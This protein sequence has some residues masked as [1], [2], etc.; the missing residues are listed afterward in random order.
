MGRFVPPVVAVMGVTVGVLSFS[1]ARSDP[2][3]AFAGDSAARAAAELAAGYALIAVGIVSWRRRPGSRCGVLLAAA[4]IA[5]FLPEFSNPAVDAP[6]VFT[7]G[8]ALYALAPP[9]VAHAA[10]AYPGGRVPVWLDRVALAFA[11]SGA[12]VVL[13]LLPAFFYDP[14]TQGCTECPANLLLVHDSPGLFDDLN[15]VGVYFGLGWSLV[16]AALLALR[17][18]RST[19][20]LR[21][22]VWPVV[23]AGAAYLGLVGLDFAHSLD[24]GFLSNDVTDVGLRLAQASALA[25]LALAVAWSWLRDRRTRGAVAR[26][27]V[28]LAESP[29]PG[30]LRDALARTLGDPSLELGYP[31]E[32]G[33][34]VDARGRALELESEVTPLVR[35]GREVAYLAHRPGLLDDP[36]L[37]EQVAAAARLALENERLQAQARAQLDDL[38]F[39]RARVIAAGDAER[40]RLE[41]DLHDGSQQRLVGLALS[42]RLARLGLGTQA[43]PSLLARIDVAEGELRTALAELREVAHGI[44]PAVLADEGLAAALEALAEEAPIP[45]KITG[46]PD[47]RFDASVEAAGYLV[48]SEAIRRGAASELSVAAARDNGRLVI[49]VASDSAPSD[50]IDLEDRVGALDG[51][52]EIVRGPG[53]S[54]RIRAEIPCES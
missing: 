24:R 6:F 3:Y 34:L 51:R 8:L 39:S 50:L 25:A 26:L 37:V 9:L 19:P 21:R 17:L 5:W 54:V 1:F 46:L 41:R 4:G 42:L 32:E 27:V 36:G 45:I 40:R 49:D 11:Y 29:A 15:R 31:L 43:D 47:E 30:G 22:L 16:L 33:R 2:G 13:G 28:Q 35:D 14:A 18:A 23:V 53:G 10:L 44:F 48:V 12:V 52:L 38:R 7:I 20:A